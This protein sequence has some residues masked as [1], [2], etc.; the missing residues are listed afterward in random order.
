LSRWVCEV[1]PGIVVPLLL[2]TPKKV[3]GRVPVVVMVSSRGKQ[4][5]FP[6]HGE[7]I[8]ALL[9][10]GIAVCLPDVRGTGET[11]PGSSAARGSA[12]TSISQTNLILGQPVIG[13]Q[14]RDLRTVIR[15]LAA[16]EEIDGEK[17]A[18][19]GEAFHTPN[20]KTT[21]LAVPLDAPNFPHIAEPAAP[22]LAL[23][24]GLYEENVALIYTHGGLAKYASLFDQPYVYV[25]HDAVV[26]GIV[27]V[28]DI[29]ALVAA[30]APRPVQ[31][32]AAIDATNRLVGA[33]PQANH[34]LAAAKDIIAKLRRR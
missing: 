11:Q 24:A 16:R 3:P 26:P 1:E 23:L 25:P 18:I 2:V 8:A 21:K 13:S 7:A 12:R 19:W 27:A 10:A 4:A 32:E 22:L 5:F 31:Q 30:L 34:P 15:W 17:I 9:Q 20:E 33:Q 28:G 29:P 6:T 14:L